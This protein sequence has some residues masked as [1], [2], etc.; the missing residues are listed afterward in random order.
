ML[1]KCAICCLRLKLLKDI[2]LR[3]SK[4]GKQD[5]RY[6]LRI[7]VAEIAGAYHLNLDTSLA[8][9]QDLRDRVI[10]KNMFRAEFSG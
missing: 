3:F 9:R 10:V 8:G 7:R 2:W 4:L 1:R 6:I 5:N